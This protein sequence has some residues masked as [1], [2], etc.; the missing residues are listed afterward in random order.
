MKSAKA[1]ARQPAAAAAA[2]RTIAN[3]ELDSRTNRTLC[4]KHVEFLAII[5]ALKKE[6][7]AALLHLAEFI[8]QRVVLSMLIIILIFLF[9]MRH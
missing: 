4:C 7:I 3:F 9:C 1:T 8:E 2:V 6:Q 5:V